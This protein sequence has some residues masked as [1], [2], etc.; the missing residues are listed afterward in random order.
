MMLLGLVLHTALGYVPSLPLAEWPY[1]D[2]QAHLGFGWLVSLIH[3][4]RMPAFFAVAGFFA[5]YLVAR[6]GTGAAF[7]GALAGSSSTRWARASGPSRGP[8]PSFR[9]RCRPDSNSTGCTSGSCTTC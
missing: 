1:Q 3:T 8:V 7:R 4:F 6:R 9:Q 2:P 5:S